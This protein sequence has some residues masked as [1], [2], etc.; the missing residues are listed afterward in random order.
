MYKGKQLNFKY[1]FS[2]DKWWLEF[3][4]GEFVMQLLRDVINNLF[5]LTQLHWNALNKYKYSSYN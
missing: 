5:T 2:R 4:L 1:L 3:S